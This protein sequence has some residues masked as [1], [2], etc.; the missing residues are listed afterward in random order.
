MYPNLFYAFRDLFGVDWKFLRFFPSFGF[1]VAISFVVSALVLRRE[2]QR[3]EAQ[4]ILFSRDESVIIGNPATPSEL[5][6]NFF[7]G[8]IVGYKFIGLFVSNSPLAN[9]PQDFILSSAGS[10]PAGIL[11]GLLFAFLKWWEKNKQKL[12]KPEERKIRIWPHDRV[13]DI[14]M[15]AA[16]FGFLGA[17]IFNSF[18]NWGDFIKNPIESLIS[19][20]GLTFYGGLICAALAIWRYAKRKGIGFWQL[21]DA[22]APT[23]MLAYAL[24]RIGCQ[25]S[26]DGDWGIPNSAYHTG[27]DQ[28]IVLN[29]GN[30][31]MMTI[32]HNDIFYLNQFGTINF[33]HKSVAA[34][35]FLP[36]WLFAYPYPH[37]VINEGVPIKDCVEQYCAV[38]PIPVFPTPLY[39]T[40]ICLGLFALIWA[41]RK[42]FRVPGTLFGFYLILNGIER[43]FIEKI[44]VNTKY[45]ILGMHPTQAEIISVLLVLSGIGIWYY[46]IR[47]AQKDSAGLVD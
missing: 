11:V 38:L 8:F 23:L 1:F 40:I 3:K 16:V 29:K 45:S 17:K 19:F 4:K 2:L 31:F 30:Q 37:N 5:L 46:Q 34:P 7:F 42:K 24:G 9:N 43:F 47:K 12:A 33:A 14:A 28:K 41:F 21:N 15:L 32:S 6:F 10:L 13:G 26:G 35:S 39:E 20:S 25:V 44:R 18:E 36:D 22:A 27:V